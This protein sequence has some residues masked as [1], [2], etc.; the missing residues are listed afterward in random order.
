VYVGKTGDRDYYNTVYDALRYNPD[1]RNLVVELLKDT[2]ETALT[3]PQAETVTLRLNGHKMSR[4]NRGALIDDGYAGA[5]F[6]IEGPGEV[7]G[8]LR[9]GGSAILRLSDVFLDG[10]IEVQSDFAGVLEVDCCVITPEGSLAAT[11]LL[12]ALHIVGADGT[13]S[14]KHSYIRGYSTQPALIYVT[15]TNNEVHARHT[16]FVHGD[17]STTPFARSAA[18][19]PNITLHNCAIDAA[20][21]AWLTNLIAAGQEFITVDTNIAFP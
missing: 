1:T 3:Y 13:I 6:I 7:E 21:P 14:I 5:E 19:T 20:I 4:A 11:S 16:T 10:G 12:G 2:V 9:V 15:N 18:Q 8:V 17:G